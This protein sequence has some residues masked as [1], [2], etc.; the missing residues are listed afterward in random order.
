M[1]TVSKA[2]NPS[3]IFQAPADVFMDILSPPSAV[4]P[5]Q[6]TNTFQLNA[7]GE[8]PDAATVGELA[9]VTLGN[10]GGSGYAV[11]DILELV[12]SGADGGLVE[13]LTLSASAVATVRVLKGGR[14]YSAAANLVTVH[15]TGAGNDAATITV[16]TIAAGFSLGLTDG[17]AS[18][19]IT[20]KFNEITADQFGGTVD[21]AFVSQSCEIDIIVKELVLKRIEKYFAGVQTGTYFNL[22]A[23]ATNPA[24]DFLQI[25]LPNSSQVNT[26]TLTLIAPRR[27]AANKWMYVHAYKT[28][29]KSSMPI[30]LDRKK[31]VLLKLKF[32]CLLDLT[33]VN[34]D[35]SMQIVRMT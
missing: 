15:R 10:A 1:P 3:D 28:Y 34:T 5:V 27:D 33:R 17:P 22:R 2:F 12:Q 11:G 13:V 14:G 16:S 4:P 25:G 8:P 6:Y 26:H 7:N 23:G 30:G 35:L 9:T 29:L 31:E 20:P 18:V 19:N 24:A 21:A 32:K